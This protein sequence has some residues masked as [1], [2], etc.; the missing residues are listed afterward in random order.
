MIYYVQRKTSAL[1]SMT[2]PNQLVSTS[3]SYT[4]GLIYVGACVA[5]SQNPGLLTD[6]Y[7]LLTS[8]SLVV[9]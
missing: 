6:I 7:A 2:Y 5:G 1:S 4:I 9:Q 8:I 3:V